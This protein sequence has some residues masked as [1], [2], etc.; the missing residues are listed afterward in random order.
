MNQINARAAYWDRA[1]NAYHKRANTLMDK[2]VKT[3]EIRWQ[4]QA[5]TNR[6]R[7]VEAAALADRLWRTARSS[8]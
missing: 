7:G 6:D 8:T 1:A 5:N 3:G 4:R 2:F